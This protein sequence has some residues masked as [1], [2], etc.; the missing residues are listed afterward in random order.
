MKKRFSFIRSVRETKG[1][2]AGSVGYVLAKPRQSLP[3]MVCR[4]RCRICFDFSGGAHLGKSEEHQE[5]LIVT[6]KTGG[7]TV[8]CSVSSTTFSF[9][10]S[11]ECFFFLTS[12]ASIIRLLHPILLQHVCQWLSCYYYCVLST[13]G[14]AELVVCLAVSDSFLWL[15]RVKGA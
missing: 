14:I 5:E 8:Q 1:G 3:A 2:K 12:G 11:F 10:C 13:F 7:E 9:S 6:K 4:S 15:A